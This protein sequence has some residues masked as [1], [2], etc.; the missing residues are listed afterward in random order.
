MRS[1]LNDALDDGAAEARVD[2]L[3]PRRLVAP[4][5]GVAAGFSVAYNLLLLV[6]PIYML[7]IYDRVLTSGSVD[8]LLLLTVLAVALLG[9]YG[10]A[11]TGRKRVFALMGTHLGRALEGE[12]FRRGMTPAGAGRQLESRVADLGRV[13]SVFSGGAVQAFFDLPFS[14]FFCLLVFLV[15]PLLGAMTVVGAV[16]LSLLAWRTERATADHLGDATRQDQVAGQFLSGVSRQHDIITA[17][18]MGERML[19]RWRALRG[20]AAT[21]GMTAGGIANV[22]GSS[23]R[24]F[25]QMLQTLILGAAAWLVLRQEISAGAIIA[26]SILSGRALAP[27]DF[28]IASW[29]PLIGAR[30]AWRQ[31]A[32]YLAVVPLPEAVTPL[33][34][35]E[36]RLVVDGLTVRIPGAEEALLT[37]VSVAIEPGKIML[38]VGASGQGK[39]ALLRTLAGVWPTAAGTVSLGGRSLH[40]WAPEDRGRHIGYLGQQLDLLP[41]TVRQNIERFGE[42]SEEPV[43]EA[44]KAV[45]AHEVLLGLPEAYDTQVLNG[46]LIPPGQRQLIGLARVDYGRPPLVLLDEPTASLDQRAVGGFERYLRGLRAS[47]RVAV[48]A[49]HDLRLLQHA[50][51]VLIIDQRRPRVVTREAFMSAIARQRPQPPDPEAPQ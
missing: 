29:R 22:Y 50:D 15:H 6:S 3:N 41:G 2:E 12:I 25:R 28:A 44:A 30:D 31:I 18:G 1:V 32:S 9:V 17:M 10:A 49:T 26:S 5:V 35:P 34:R 16:I 11:E 48:I 19:A 8:T 21:A 40:G 13:Q 51:L 43:F 47:G 39:S 4:F 46:G 33:D 23:A 38:V 14:P 37:P 36:P 27:I 45:G 20:R 24:S 7:Q 42:G